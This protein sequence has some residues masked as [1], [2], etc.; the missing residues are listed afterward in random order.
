MGW[1]R[2]EPLRIVEITNATDVMNPPLE[3]R[4]EIIKRLGGN[5]CHFICMR[6]AAVDGDS[7]LDDNELYFETRRANKKNPD[8]LK[9]FVRLAHRSGIRV[10]VY[11]NVHWYRKK[12]AR[13]TGWG[14]IREDGSLIDN[15]YTTGSSLCINSGWR[16]WVFDVVEDL[17]RYDIDG[18]FYDGPI[19]FA[20]TCYCESCRRLFKEEYGEEI[21]K[22]SN[23]SDPLWLK[24]IEFQVASLGRFLKETNE[25]IKSKSSE[26]LFYMN[27]NANWPYWPTGRDNREIIKYTDILGAE[28]GFIYGDLNTVPFYK[29]GVTAKLL[30]S[31]AAGKPV[32]VFDCAGHKS[33]SWYLLPEKEVKLLMSE[34]I[35]NGGNVWISIFPEDI[36]DENVIGGIAQIN[37]R[38][39]ENKDIF[40]GT[41]SIANVALLYPMISANI[42]RGSTVPLTDF[43]AEMEREKVGDI[44][45]EFNGFYEILLRNKI[46]FDVI[47]EENLR[48]LSRYEV[49]ILPNAA[50]LSSEHVELIR[51][52]VRN[53]GTLIASFESSLYDERGRKLSNFGL[54]DLFGVDCGQEILNLERWNY[55]YPDLGSGLLDGIVKKYLPSTEYGLK[56]EPKTG[57]VFIY[58]YEKL[59][60]RLDRDP[61]MSEIPFAVFNSYGEGVA[62]YF[63]GTFGSTY[64]RYRFP[65]YSLILKNLLGRFSR[66]LIDLEEEWVEVVL[67]SKENKILIH[68]INLITGPKRPFTYIKRLEDLKIRLFVPHISSARSV[69]LRE[70]LNFEKKE[71]FYEITLPVLNE[72][73]L[74][75]IE[76]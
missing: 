69:F 35:S 74:V 26:I 59:R 13:R 25:I 38:I 75:C 12:F 71:D 2:K 72:Y 4:V 11:F 58:F 39:L 21:P 45:E 43:T 3:K 9:D 67:R 30:N 60:G 56:T 29:P 40:Y 5:V 32:V 44:Y 61:S 65:E 15:V 36:R 6:L 42:Y 18:I 17:C 46:Q 20:D 34:T 7:G 73:D 16:D 70:H 8:L 1:W 14:Q 68:L 57:N 66:K 49:L 62:I 23:Y 33:W 28:G 10:V 24:L 51:Q 53:G 48:D 22:K 41:E 31:Q 50:C 76:V 55:I 52:F 64:Y 47:D 37:N 54:S 63:S 19:F 27:G